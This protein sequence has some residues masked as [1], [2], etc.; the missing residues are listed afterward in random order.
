MRQIPSEV[1]VA[2]EAQATGVL[3][4]W[5]LEGELDP[6]R[7]KEAWFA[8]RLPPVFLP[9]KQTQMRLLSQFLNR[10]IESHMFANIVASDTLEVE[11]RFVGTADYGRTLRHIKLFQITQKL[12]AISVAL[13]DKSEET[14]QFVQDLV[15]KINNGALNMLSPNNVSAWLISLATNDLR[16]LSLRERGG[17]YIV[18]K[19][20]MELWR[21]M[22]DVIHTVSAHK[23]RTLPI[24]ACDEAI[25]IVLKAL[26]DD[27]AKALAD[28]AMILKRPPEDLRIKQLQ[29]MEE[30]LKLQST[31]I[32]SYAKLLNTDM[33]ELLNKHNE[34]LA[35][36]TTMVFL[37]GDL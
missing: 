2:E 6:E 18:P 37:K 1:V 34:L 31:K 22:R 35:G 3:T 15:G 4:W 7:L 12:D 33:S 30:T 16:G 8:A 14:T 32:E 9:K 29:K 23:I 5:E 20:H 10:E 19:T 21:C 24:M 36:I 27:T 17:F 13:I 11:S 25:E 28:Y 26:R